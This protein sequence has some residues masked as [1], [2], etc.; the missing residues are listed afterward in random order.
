MIF[1]IS[2][3]LG[4][5]LASASAA[6]QASKGGDRLL[7]LFDDWFVEQG[8][9]LPRPLGIGVAA[10]YMNR[11]VEVTD[12]RVSFGDRP[13]QSIS[14]RADFS[15]RNATSLITTRADAWILP[16]LNVYGM[17]GHTDSEARLSTIISIPTP[18]PG[19]P[20]TTEI[21]ADSTVSGLLYGA[22]LTAVVGVNDWFA[23]ADANYGAS[24][25]DG[26]EGKL[27]VWL[28]S[29]R[30]GRV[31]NRGNRQFMAWGGVLYIDSERTITIK[32]DLP[33][34][35]ETIVDVDQRPV[36][37]LTY[38]LGGSMTINTRWHFLLEAGS[39]F[40]DATIVVGSA[41]YRF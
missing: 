1:R 29:G 8:I 23:M 11:D 4:L 32:T 7:P 31:F 35:G 37:P 16:F 25:L 34:I 30:F 15:V 13:P 10:I 18:G 27:D 28:L 21:T 5:L 14:D 9:E 17:L 26:F 38:Q 20:I 6:A 39:N 36:D 2:A 22:G 24:D 41:T 19:D 40:D 12:V 3:C 33:I